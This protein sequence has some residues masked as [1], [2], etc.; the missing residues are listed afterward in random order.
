MCWGIVST[1]SLV[2]FKKVTNV[3]CAQVWVFAWLDTRKQRYL[4]YAIVYL[5]PYLRYVILCVRLYLS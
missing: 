1:M 5:A 2:Y 4:I 3:L